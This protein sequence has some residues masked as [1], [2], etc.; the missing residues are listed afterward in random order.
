MTPYVAG[1]M[2]F[3]ES[4]FLKELP[5]DPNLP[6]LFIGEEILHSIRFYTHGWDIFT[7]TQNVV[8][9]EYTRANKPKIWTDNPYYVDEPAF[10]KVKH[11]LKLMDEEKDIEG[12]LKFNLDKYGLG[13]KRTL[14]DYYNFAGIDIENKKVYKNFCKENNIAT[15]ED[16]L[17][18]NE[19]N[20][21]KSIESFVNIYSNKIYYIII[22]IILVLLMLILIVYLIYN[23]SLYLKFFKIFA[24]ILKSSR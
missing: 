17:M 4:Y 12:Y 7:P 1:G 20:H 3:C 5:F 21:K 8:F 19:M 10:N 16:I 14:E 15:E 6:F 22:F 13:N 9:H 2:F 24:K 18:S 11:Y 23:P